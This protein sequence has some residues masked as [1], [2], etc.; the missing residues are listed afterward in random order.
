[1]QKLHQKWKLKNIAHWIMKKQLNLFGH[2]CRIK[3]NRLTKLVMFGKL[4]MEVARAVGPGENG[5]MTWRTDIIVICA[6]SLDWQ[7]QKWVASICAADNLHDQAMM[8][9]LHCVPK[10]RFSYGLVCSLWMY[11]FNI[12]CYYPKTLTSKIRCY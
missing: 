2:V 7:K 3:D 11:S 12:T 6:Y 1:M 5:L 4:W 9:Y 8:S 10:L